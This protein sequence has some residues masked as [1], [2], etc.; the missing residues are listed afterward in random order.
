MEEMDNNKE[1]KTKKLTKAQLAAKQEE[2]RE[3]IA[4]NLDN[5]SIATEIC[6]SV[7]EVDGVSEDVKIKAN[8]TLLAVLNKL[9]EL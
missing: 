2:V 4:F 8:T 1:T 9:Q 7:L 5:Y 6:L 3:K